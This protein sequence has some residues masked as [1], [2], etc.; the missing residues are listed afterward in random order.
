VTA[1][2][3]ESRRTG[4]SGLAKLAPWILLVCGSLVYANTFAVPFLFDDLPTIVDNQD[5][6]RFWPVWHLFVY[7]GETDIGVSGRPIANVSFALSY[8]LGGLN[9][10]GYHAFNLV[11]HVGA[12][13]LLFG[14]V[15]RTLRSPRFAGRFESSAVAI[16]FAVAL[17]WLVHPLQTKSVTFIAQ[18]IE[19]LAAFFYLLTLYAFVRGATSSHTSKPWMSVAVIA[20]ALGMATK[21]IVVSVPIVVFLFDATFVAGSWRGALARWK[22]HAALAATWI[23]LLVLLLTTARLNVVMDTS[24][25]LSPLDYLKTQSAAL[26]HYVRLFVWPAPLV[27]DYGMAGDGVPLL[28]TPSEY[29]PYALPLALVAAMTAVGVL[30]LRPWAFLCATFFL[31]LAPSSSVV[32][33]RLDVM[34]EHRVYLPIA[35]LLLLACAGAAQ[36]LARLGKDASQIAWIALALAVPLGAA[37]F[38]RNRD[39]A[40]DLSIW[41]DTVEK[42][43]G[44]ARA[45]TNLGIALFDR[46]DYEGAIARHRDAIRLRPDYSEAYHNLASALMYLERPQE[47]EVQ[48]RKA[49]ELAPKAWATHLGLAEALLA[50]EKHDESA[51]SFAA[52]LSIHPDIASAYVRLGMIRQMQGNAEEAARLYE[53]SLRRSPNDVTVLNQLGLA[54]GQLGRFDL[55][56]DRFGRALRVDPTFEAARTNLER[57]RAA[58]AGK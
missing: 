17:L 53:E 36:L 27:F 22:C 35:A 52:A 18:R 43:P 15:R 28:T 2:P 31:I 56:A 45:Q 25:A 54:Y 46:G 24:T 37:T 29:L 8:A 5:I 19:S 1:A 39:F 4:T 30:K 11:V 32:P 13:L 23:V 9:V 33:I 6:R 3:A 44:S 21:E 48:Y 16:A 12:G 40:S 49:L 7:S 10:A 14:L 55:A 47:A 41:T 58:A 57:A 34:A 20:A 42:L 38:V 51:A 50:Q 26:W